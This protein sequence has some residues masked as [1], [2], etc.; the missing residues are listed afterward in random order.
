[1]TRIAEEFCINAR[2][3]VESNLPIAKKRTILTRLA[4]Q[5][6]MISE[7]SPAD[8]SS[9]AAQPLEMEEKEQ[10]QTVYRCLKT[11]LFRMGSP[12]P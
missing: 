12:T 1:M 3:I 9:D 4:K 2:A 6:E 8:F 10:L 7:L 11:A 5:V